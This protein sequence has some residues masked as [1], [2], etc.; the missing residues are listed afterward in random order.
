VAH[1][2]LPRQ[3]SLAQQQLIMTWE[4]SSR[5]RADPAGQVFPA[6]I[7]YQVPAQFL[8]GTRSLQLTATRLGI[9]PQG[10]CRS[11]V[12]P[13]A[14]R[15]L[16]AGH[17]TALLRATYVD[18]SQSMVVTLGI[19]V[20]PDPKFALT[21]ARQLSEADHGLALMVRPFP[22]PGTEA[23]RFRDDE[24]QLDYVVGK[25]PYVIMSTAGFADGRPHVE[26]TIDRYYYQEMT[27]LVDG[28]AE[29][30]AWRIGAQPVV[31]RCP[32]APGC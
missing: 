4:M 26:L 19:A 21:A 23:A 3:F 32:G 16:A 10:S 6:S 15:V 17:C 18:A 27:S 7:G 8:E 20:L 5:W 13:A 11:D 28:L 22:V 25:G 14:A 29:S 1:E 24:R 30:I 12:S 31:P 2:L 9:A